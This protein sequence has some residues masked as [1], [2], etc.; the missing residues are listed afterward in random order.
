M[1]HVQWRHHRREEDS[2]DLLAIL[3][4]GA[5]VRWLR[6][7][8]TKH[9]AH[10]S[11]VPAAP[12]T[13]ALVSACM[14]SGQHTSG[15]KRR[16]VLRAVYG[17]LLAFLVV[18]FALLPWPAPW[19]MS[20]ALA[21]DVQRVQAFVLRNVDVVT[22]GALA[23]AVAEPLLVGIVGLLCQIAGLL[24]KAVCRVP[25]LLWQIAHLTR[26]II[27]LGYWQVRR[28]RAQQRWQQYHTRAS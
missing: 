28:R 25:H 23:L 1:G 27:A 7:Y 20:A 17:M 4:I 2:M 6:R 15:A 10:P 19:A 3:G 14:P 26:L 11:D 13:T 8:G 9:T 5:F 16:L 21:P 22:F 18:L 24:F 12:T